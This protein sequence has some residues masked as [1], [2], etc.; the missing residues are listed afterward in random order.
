MSA[1]RIL[2]LVLISTVATL[3]AFQCFAGEPGL[4]FTEDFADTTLRNATETT[5]N[6]STLE[7]AMLLN[8]RGP[9][10]GAFG[11]GLEGSVITAEEHDTSSL[12][13][14]D[15]EGD[16]DLDL[17]EGNRNEPCRLYFNDGLTFKGTVPMG[18]DI[19][20][21]VR[22][23]RS[24]AVGDLDGDGDLDVVTGNFG[25]PNRLYLNNG[26]LFPFSGVV[27]SDITADADDT[28]SVVLGDLD[29]DGDLDLVAGNTGTPNR[30]YLNNG[31]S[32][33][34]E[35][36]TG[37]A[38]TA[39]A[40]ATNSVA[41]GDLDSDGDVDLV[42]ANF[43]QPSQIYLNNGTSD[44]FAGV[45]GA[46]FAPNSSDIEPV[47]VLGDM[48]GDGNLDIIR[49]GGELVEFDQ[50]YFNNGTANP[51]EGV[52][53]VPINSDEDLS[54][55]VAVGD[56]DC[57][58]DLDVIIGNV[59][60]FSDGARNRLYLNNGTPDPFS[61]V[62]GTNLTEDINHTFALALG[63][64]DEDGDLDAI[65]G[66]RN[67]RNRLY[68]NEGSPNPF[69]PIDF[70]DISTEM[71]L[72]NDLAVGD[73]DLDGDLDLVV[74]N[75]GMPNR[76]Y[77]N[78]GTSNPFAGVAPSDIT[79]DAFST[80][81]V[82]LGDVDTD[83]DLD[84]VTA[85]FAGPANRLY[86]NNGTSNPFEGVT[87]SDIT[88]DASVTY[89]V[90]LG[91]L[92]ADGD[93]DLVAG[94]L[95]GPDRL[96]LNNGTPNPFAD[97][98]GSDI[99]SDSTHTTCVALG[100]VDCDGDLDLVSGKL[101]QGVR[102]HRL[103]LNNGTT[104]PFAD[105]VGMDIPSDGDG[106]FS[107]ALGDLDGDGD[108]DIVTANAGSPD[109][110]YLNNGTSEPFNGV[111][112]RDISADSDTSLRVAMGDVDGDGDLDII[113]GNSG[114]DF[115]LLY[116]NNG[117]SDPFAD[118]VGAMFDN[119]TLHKSV[120]LG[121]V[122][123]DGDLDIVAGNYFST[124]RL[125]A[126][127]S[128]TVPFNALSGV[129]ITADGHAT[130]S[131][132]VGDLDRDGALDVVA[133]NFG[134]PSR[135]YLNNGKMDPLEEV[136]G[137]NITA[138]AQQ[139]TSV[140]L[141]DVDKD[142][143]LDLVAGNSGQP[144]RFYPNN[145]S[146]APFDGIT[147]VNITADS[148]STTSLALG[149]IDRDGDEDLVAGNFGQ[150]NRMYLNNGS[151]DPWTGVTGVDITK[152]AQ[153]TNSVALGDVDRDGFL[154]LVAGNFGQPNRLYLNQLDTG[155][156]SG[157]HEISSATGLAASIAVGDVDGDG[158]L[159]LVEG[160]DSDPRLPARLLLNNGTPDPFAGVVATEIIS[161]ATRT[162]TLALGDLNG[163]DRLD[164]ILDSFFQ[165]LQLFLNNGSDSPFS[166]VV[167]KD[168]TSDLPDRTVVRGLALGDMDGDEDLD[169]VASRDPGTKR[170]YLNN[171]TSEPFAGVAG[172][173]ITSETDGTTSLAVGDFDG[174]GDLDLA[175]SYNSFS[176]PNRLFLNNGTANPFLGVIGS[177]I[178]SDASITVSLAA[179]DLNGDGHLDLVAGNLNGSSRLFLNNGT[180]NPFAGVNGVSIDPTMIY[181][182]TS[183]ALGDVDG[184]EDLDLVLGL[185]DRKPSRLYLNNGGSNPFEGVT[186]IDLGS[187]PEETGEVEELA[188]ADMDGD[189]DLDLVVGRHREPD[190]LFFNNLIP[191]PFLTGSDISPDADNTNSVVI[192]DIDLDGRLDVVA[193]NFNQP[194][195]WYHNNGTVN[196]FEGATVIDV[197]EETAN[198]EE[199]ALVD[200]NRDGRLDLLTGNLGQPNRVYMNIDLVIAFP[201]V[202]AEGIDISSDADNT[203][204]LAVTDLD[205]D[206]SLDIVSGNEGQA[207]RL[208]TRKRFN[209]SS[210]VATSLTVDTQPG[211]IHRIILEAEQALPPNTGI[212]YW[213]SGNG[214]L[215]WSL[216]QPSKL[217]SFPTLG[218]DLRWRA[219]LKSLSPRFS[220]R[221]E[222]LFL[223]LGPGIEA[224]PADIDFMDRA[225]NSGPSDPV[226]VTIENEGESN[227]TISGVLLGGA[228]AG[229]FVFSND[230]GEIVLNPGG[231]R[232][233]DVAFNPT[234]QGP[235]EATIT[236]TSND[237]DRPLVLVS[238]LGTGS[239]PATPTLTPTLTTTPTFTTTPSST[240][241]ET[242]TAVFS[243]TPTQAETNYDIHPE[244]P[245]GLVNA[246]DLLE[247]LRLLEAP[248][249][250]RNLLFDFARFWKT[251]VE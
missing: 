151:S 226:T 135:L 198:T 131:V 13:L 23:T 247:W 236:I 112:R 208:Y 239:E 121:D 221:L 149:D 190:D 128:A 242:T 232:T 164:L 150:I 19:T 98:V 215:R 230:S 42:V 67:Q 1:H 136:S 127:S 205:G 44:P 90:V 193:G 204:S 171:G 233:F 223:D 129:E 9:R 214:G 95:M 94:N 11:P 40:F 174:D 87:G 54:F 29:G 159:D 125:Y 116:L 156:F 231:T 137:E 100:D 217:F 176:V 65:A 91:D 18:F 133:G 73:L 162:V 179:G 160:K 35:G 189:G 238:L 240:P 213:V 237:I 243:E 64:V 66:N 28:A 142:G 4:P 97:V 109:R 143:D 22:D 212:E 39:N 58:G 165:P 96:Y 51:F 123:G 134:Q 84:L 209:T 195:R 102:N 199:I 8:P 107:I 113:M 114:G 177:D 203:R 146:E 225:P 31:T 5:A 3:L 99:D 46:E 168:I 105:V 197:G 6:W 120:A 224:N 200:I 70:Y 144:N 56:V 2:H 220:P 21:D 167:G 38:I 183:T 161:P 126:N 61:D 119:E 153:N 169:V 49:V 139:T 53:G 108:L 211:N 186:G 124:T 194:N 249:S 130:R 178:P 93:L 115:S 25:A 47:I 244:Q 26:A 148:N 7:E 241:T 71:D 110:L 245:D 154:D 248:A 15:M 16:G 145:G 10:Y 55:S 72:T 157:G 235:K 60:L 37:V 36:V 69:D 227:V 191:T 147:G 166:G 251:S 57:D 85:N 101:G 188:M 68:L 246:G 41:L 206:G 89:S 117:T 92:D 82:A 27:G 210:N 45:T 184:D 74:G 173:D 83:G 106:I 187:E 80:I 180:A 50:V 163:D 111:L 79:S 219:V 30:L 24:V 175:V 33:P 192:G 132:A 250:D 216:V 228:D 12:A 34:F 172:S 185:F 77:L 152:D 196:P 118:V 140:A 32:A 155:P 201:F 17:V 43:Q 14:G 222:T 62:M 81:S 158:D 181:I 59:G 138:D 52:T 141:G 103:Y 218:S 20:S 104:D 78:N 234:S 202:G 88:S 63:D 182:V 170:L 75:E 76:L 229:Q 86:R 207:N 122:D 48:N